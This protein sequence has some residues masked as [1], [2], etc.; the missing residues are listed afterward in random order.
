[1]SVIKLLVGRENDTPSDATISL[2][3]HGSRQ[4]IIMAE[5]MNPHYSDIDTYHM[6]ASAIDE[7]VRRII[8]SGGKLPSKDNP[9][10]ALDNFCWNLSSLDNADGQFKLAQLVRACKALKDYCLAFKLP[11]I[12]GKDSMKNVWRT[13]E[14]VEGKKVET[15][16]SI[17]PT[18]MFSARARI[19]D[20]SRTVTMDLKRPGD[21]IYVVGTTYDET[22]GSEY[23]HYLGEKNSGKGFVGNKVPKVN[24]R[25][26]R[27]IYQT[28]SE[29]IEKGLV[30]SVHT[31]T[32]G[33]LGVALALTSFAGGF[34]M[35]VDLRKVPCSKVK[36][37]DV[38][39]FSESNSR[40]VISIPKEKKGEFEEIMRG[41]QYC[42]IG[43]V[44]ESRL[45]RI[46]GL[47]GRYVIDAKIDHLKNVW[48]DVMKGV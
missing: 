10:Y 17:P 29:A 47:S 27:R 46:K 41:I 6:V 21:L 12:S 13:E 5:G 34:G 38:L 16:I 31:P 28:V 8:A 30:H 42:Q 36:R 39:L 14:T 9:F 37:N 45:L 33:G 1:L 4:G 22:G 20:V 43:K 32:I 44:T 2:L 25:K 26:A 19:S 11:C 15:I 40:F 3:E 24:A 7:A 23:Y 18:L 48:K 35:D